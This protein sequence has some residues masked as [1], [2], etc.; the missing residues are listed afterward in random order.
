MLTS[1]LRTGHPRFFLGSDSA[2]HPLTSKLPSTAVHGASALS[3]ACAAG[4]Y[5]SPILLPLC[6]TLLE[7]FGALHNLAGYVST[8]GRAFYDIPAPAGQEVKLR[9]A[10][11]AVVQAYVF[12]GHEDKAKGDP[13]KIEVVPFLAGKELGWEIVQ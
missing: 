4:I 1:S 8:H 3:H 10:K 13:D 9:R 11:S 12:P 5:T 2:P 7:S 6:A